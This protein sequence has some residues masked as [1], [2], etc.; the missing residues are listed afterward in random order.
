MKTRNIAILLLIVVAVGGG[1]MIYHSQPKF[2]INTAEVVAQP[3][4]SVATSTAASSSETVPINDSGYSA[5]ADIDV[6]NIQL[7]YDNLKGKDRLY[8]E[9]EGKF[10]NLSEAEK[11]LMLV[12]L[13]NPKC[14]VWCD[15]GIQNS[16]LVDLYDNSA[17]ILI[18]NGKGGRF[19]QFY[20]FMDRKPVGETI[21]SYDFGIR[22]K[23]I[24]VQGDD[25]SFN[26]SQLIYYKHGSGAFTLLPGS[27][28]G[29]NET[30][31][32]EINLGSH[33][34]GRIVDNTLHISIFDSQSRGSVKD[35]TLFKETRTATFDLS[36]LP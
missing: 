11:E 16:Y 30:Y 10:E 7:D 22:A 5:F 19:F 3:I 17:L 9:E 27:T 12:A 15:W 31:L 28:L 2:E 36:T 23:D 6:N 24:I 13:Y 26:T 1:F 33:I 18:P 20:N 25:A 32:N 29:E 34:E 4:E 14:Q 35:T 21:Y 8:T